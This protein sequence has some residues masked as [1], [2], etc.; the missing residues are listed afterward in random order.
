MA[1]YRLRKIWSIKV[2]QR[3]IL[4]AVIPKSVACNVPFFI[5]RGVVVLLKF[6][7]AVRCGL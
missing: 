5:V 3:K 4:A 7:A 2:R 6:K 1:M